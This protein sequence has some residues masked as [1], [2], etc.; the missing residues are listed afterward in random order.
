MTADHSASEKKSPLFSEKLLHKDQ[1]G[2]YAVI[3]AGFW[4]VVLVAFFL[5]NVRTHNQYI[6]NTVLFQAR[7]FFD[8]ILTTRAWNASHGG[9]YVPITGRDLAQSLSPRPRSRSF[10]RGRE[11]ADQDK[12]CLYDQAD[13]RDC[14]RSQRGAF[15]YHQPAADPARK[16]RRCM[17]TRRPSVPSRPRARRSWRNSMAQT[18]EVNFRYMAPLWVEKSCLPCHQEQGYKVGDRRGGI[19]ITIPAKKM[20]QL[21]RRHILGMGFAYL[22]I[23]L[24]GLTR[25]GRRVSTVEE[26]RRTARGAHRRS[27]ESTG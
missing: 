2:R 3:T 19:S 10:D 20:L 9:V 11:K 22:T 26:E 12:P 17:G 16:C 14:R 13:F 7:A 18:A 21:H 8:Q 25:I 23:W 1:L 5:W 24:L 27:P 4:T 15:P 6:R